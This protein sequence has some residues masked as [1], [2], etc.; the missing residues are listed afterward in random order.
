MGYFF[1]Q[2][3]YGLRMFWCYGLRFV[4]LHAIVSVY[5]VYQFLFRFGS[6]LG[7]PFKYEQKRRQSVKVSIFYIAMV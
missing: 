1:V 6:F 2:R 7:L 5:G 3:H 4:V